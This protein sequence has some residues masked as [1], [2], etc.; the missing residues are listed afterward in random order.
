MSGFEASAG[1][2]A[3]LGCEAADR[4]ECAGG[5]IVNGHLTQ[6]GRRKLSGGRFA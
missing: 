3:G 4:R 5:A 6:S 2:V 1:G